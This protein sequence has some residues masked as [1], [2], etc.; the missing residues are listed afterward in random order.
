MLIK[1]GQCE[2]EAI[3]GDIANQPNMVAIVNA[4]NAEL[5]MGGGVAGAIHK[6]AGPELEKECQSLAPITPGKAVITQAYRLPNQYII[7]CLGPIYGF[8][9]PEDKL[10]A[11]CY[12]NALDLADRKQIHSIAFPA[13][14]TGAFGYPI[15]LATQVAL[16]TVYQMIPTLRYV[17]RIRFVLFSK[18]DLKIYEDKFL[19]IFNAKDAL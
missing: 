10:L 16:D 7:H 18:A 8:D 11:S 3:Q 15:N 5:R 9:K 4:A 2:L 14:S 19:S 12:R 6:A 13:I 1:I 17:K